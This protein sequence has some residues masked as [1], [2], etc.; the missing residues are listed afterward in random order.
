MTYLAVKWDSQFDPGTGAWVKCSNL[1]FSC[2]FPWFFCG[3]NPNKVTQIEI[4]SL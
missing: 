4:P 3:K 1:T 2:Y